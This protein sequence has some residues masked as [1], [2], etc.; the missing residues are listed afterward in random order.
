MEWINTENYLPEDQEIVLVCDIFNT[1]I[2]LGKYVKEDDSF[3][4]MSIEKVQSDSYPSHWM[5]LPLPP[6][7]DEC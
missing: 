4:I 5:P 2:S 1:F 7:E 3:M 6:K